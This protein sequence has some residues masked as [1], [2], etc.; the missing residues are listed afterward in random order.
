MQGST[1]SLLHTRSAA[2]AAVCAQEPA[3]SSGGSAASSNSSSSPGGGSNSSSRH[4]YEQQQEARHSITQPYGGA[5]AAA[6]V[7]APGPKHAVAFEAALSSQ[8]Q[9]ASSWNELVTLLLNYS[10]TAKG[11]S[12]VS[13]MPHT[14]APSAAALASPQQAAAM[15][16]QQRRQKML[17]HARQQQ[18][19]QQAE[20][21]LSTL[22]QLNSKHLARLLKALV[23][24][25]LPQQ[26]QSS[27]PLAPAAA[28]A[29][30]PAGVMLSKQE[31]Q[32]F[33]AL[34]QAAFSECMEQLPSLS[35]WELS[36][37]LWAASKL[38]HPPP[39]FLLR[40]LLQQ[41]AQPGVLAAA[42]AQDISMSL[43]AVAS[44]AVQVPEQQLE[45]LLAASAQHMQVRSCS[46][47]LDTRAASV[48]VA[49]LQG[50][51][52][53]QDRVSETVTAIATQNLLK[54][55]QYR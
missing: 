9:K 22:H 53:C 50:S 15:Q 52:H 7:A 26:Q 41:L 23:S 54:P 13:N 24:L 14:R 16:Q 27:T 43:H 44:L 10:S 1:K 37:T 6:R 39:P 42:S 3:A 12:S 33:W 55:E 31:Q 36:S 48:W 21:V 25:Q 35:A 17:Q 30:Q 19:Q 4:P 18:Q 2:A 32:L 5:P 34:A 38:A 46:A 29:R 49:S 47:L 8:M 45:V 51:R 20:A 28:A 40:R 11:G